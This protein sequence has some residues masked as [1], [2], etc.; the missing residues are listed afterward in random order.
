[1]PDRKRDGQRIHIAIQ[2][3]IRAGFFY[4]IYDQCK[5][6]NGVRRQVAVRTSATRSTNRQTRE[7]PISIRD[8]LCQFGRGTKVQTCGRQGNRFPFRRSVSKSQQRPV[9]REIRAYEKVSA[10]PHETTAVQVAY[11]IRAATFL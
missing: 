9:S 11:W 7:S 1:M 6:Q 8:S 4:R 10:I 3:G 5:W 2:Q